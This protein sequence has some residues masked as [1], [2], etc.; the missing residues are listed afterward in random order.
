MI[1]LAHKNQA[2]KTFTI[3]LFIM[4]LFQIRSY[5]QTVGISYVRSIEAKSLTHDQNKTKISQIR[6]EIPE[7]ERLW[8]LKIQKVKDDISTLIKERDALIAD[9]K[10]GARCSQC[11]GWK[12]DFEKKGENFEKHLGD[13]KGYAI[14]AT[15]SELETTRKQFAEKIAIKKVQLQNLEKGDEAMLRKLKEIEELEKANVKIC[16]D[17]PELSKGYEE[18]VLA[19]GKS[20]HDLWTKDLLNAA[21]NI[22]IADDKITIFKDQVVRYEK[23][24]QK[25][26]EKIRELVKK[27]NQLA[28]D[29]KNNA[30]ATNE[31][32][33]NTITETKNKYIAINDIELKKLYQLK[34]EIERELSKSLPDSAKSIQIS[35]QKQIIEKI[36]VLEKSNRDYTLEAESKIV[37]L[38][39]TM[40]KLKED[41][42][43]LNTNLPK[44]QELA[45]LKIKPSFDQKK[46]AARESENTAVL[47]LASAKKLYLE[48][49][50]EYKR[51]NDAFTSEISTES[52]RMLIAGQKINC[53]IWNQARG[54]VVTNWNQV[55]PCVNNLTTMAKPYST[56][57]FNAYCSGKSLASYMSIYKSFLMGLS[58]EDREAVKAN[59][60]AAWYEQLTM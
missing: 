44:V 25:E 29:Q 12:S 9:M 43:H 31:Q 17:M 30:I 16:K 45:I 18:S 46:S 36:A 37:A 3:G 50:N 6:S 49:A 58:K 28:V 26:S 32:Q 8:R 1:H 53:P 41:I 14:P 52:N 40:L 24:F 56:N 48:K 23:E 34:G 21:T 27:E 4:V 22:L 5:S 59:S 55:F 54:M 13:V 19:D 10:V 38:K 60:N 35:N 47:T 11:N 33:I 7:L 57:V 42:F 39:N 51:K 15:T 2:M 20:K